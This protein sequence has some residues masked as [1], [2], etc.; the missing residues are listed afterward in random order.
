VVTGY[1][2]GGNLVS[3]TFTALDMEVP[4]QLENFSKIIAASLNGTGTAPE[5]RIQSIPDI[6]FFKDVTLTGTRDSDGYI[7]FDAPQRI[8]IKMENSTEAADQ[9]FRVT[10]IDA[11]THEVVTETIHGIGYNAAAITGHYFD[12][13][14]SVEYGA[15]NASASQ[16]V[17]VGTIGEPIV[18]E[19]EMSRFGGT[20]DLGP[21]VAEFGTASQVTLSSADADLSGRHFTITG[22]LADGTVVTEELHGPNLGTV[23]SANS[24]LTVND[25]SVDGGA[26]GSVKVGYVTTAGAM[27]DHFVVTGDGTAA[28]PL[29]GYSTNTMESYE[30]LSNGAAQSANSESDVLLYVSF[31]GATPGTV[32]LHYN[33]SVQGTPEQDTL[34]VEYSPTQM[35]LLQGTAYFADGAKPTRRCS[36]R[37][38]RA[39]PARRSMRAAAPPTSPSSTTTTR[40]RWIRRRKAPPKEMPKTACCTSRSPA[41]RPWR[42]TA[43]WRGT[44]T[45]APRAPTISPMSPRVR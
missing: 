10:G 40:C 4:A 1:D 42:S 35:G 26:T 12:K 15:A 32:N 24:F 17:S 36:S 44:S 16:T 25:I 13:L 30:Q 11:V 29:T 31:N 37:S 19:Q 33:L 2:S 5:I 14:L 45:W 34:Y 21:A 41:P 20:V 9:E 8:V 23:H 27:V 28:D 22:T 39:E 7:D 43:S 18:P 6:D 3:Q 38:R